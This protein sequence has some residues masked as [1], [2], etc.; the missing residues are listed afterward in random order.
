[1]Q[2]KDYLLYYKITLVLMI[3]PEIHSILEIIFNKAQAQTAKF[4]LERSYYDITVS[5]GYYIL[6]QLPAKNVHPSESL[7]REIP[8]PETMCGFM[9]QFT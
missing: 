2:Y 8:E 6:R 4:T 7:K 9:S 3:N 5:L 1:M